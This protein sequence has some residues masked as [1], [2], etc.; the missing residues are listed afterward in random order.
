MLKSGVLN[1]TLKFPSPKR[2]PTDPLF[3][4]EGWTPC[5][6]WTGARTCATGAGAATLKGWGAATLLV[7][8]GRDA[9][10]DLEDPE[11]AELTVCETRGEI[12]EIIWATMSDWED[13][14]VVAVGRGAGTLAGTEMG[15]GRRDPETADVT[16]WEIRGCTW[17]TIW[18]TMS[19][20]RLDWETEDCWPEEEEDAPEEDVEEKDELSEDPA[21]A[22]D[23]AAEAL[24]VTKFSWTFLVSWYPMGPAV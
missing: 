14:E 13:V 19:D 9:K 1:L 7:G 15:A 5:G 4:D 18:E 20:W 3:I 11:T 12:W 17:E 16:V 21:E 23:E 6:A 2:L 24:I 10:R 22:P 8:A